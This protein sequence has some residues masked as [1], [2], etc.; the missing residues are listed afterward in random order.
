M[1]IAASWVR[2]IHNCEEFLFLIVDYV[3]DIAGTS[4][5]NLQLCREIHVH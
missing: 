3:E 2:K 1:T 5:Q 4:V